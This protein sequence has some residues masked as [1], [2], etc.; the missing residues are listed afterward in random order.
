MT[1]SQGDDNTSV[2]VVKK[3]GRAIRYDAVAAIIAALVGLLALFVAGYTAYIQ[4]QQ[5][6]AQVWPYLSIGESDALPSEMGHV[7]V[8]KQGEI[9]SH[10]GFLVVQ[11]A[12]VGPA[13]VRSVVVEVDGKPQPDWNQVMKTLGLSDVAFIQSAINHSVLPAGRTV[14]FLVVHGLQ[15]WKRFRQGYFHDVSIRICYSSTLGDFW[16]TVHDPLDH[17]YRRG[18]SVDAC[19]HVSKAD[20]FHG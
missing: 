3:P 13:I 15:A 6:Q 18:Q 11:N 19:P 8:N 4:R 10:G 12:G 9:E 17:D 14:N 1:E 7:V 16:T 2:P 5:V 20:D